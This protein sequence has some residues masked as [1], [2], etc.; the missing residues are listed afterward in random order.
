M[1]LSGNTNNSIFAMNLQALS[2]IRS[3]QGYVFSLYLDTRPEQIAG[4][5][6][7]SRFDRFLQ[8]TGQQ[9]KIHQAEPAER[10]EWNRNA[11]QIR[12]RLEG[13]QPVQGPGLAI[14]S[15]LA[16]DLWQVFNLPVP[17]ADRLV[18]N[19]CPYVRPL[20]ILLA[21]FKCTL[22]ILADTGSARL[23]Q[24]YPGA[25][26]EVD[27]LASEAVPV[28][29]GAED[30]NRFARSIVERIEAAWREKKCER[31]V[32][33]GSA[34]ALA[35]LENHLPDP[36]RPHVSRSVR[37]SPQAGLED[38][39][40]QVRE[41]E[42]EQEHNLET[43]RV[44]ELLAGG[45]PED[46]SAVLGLEQSLLAVRSK[47]VRVLV[48]EE[49]FHREGGVCPNCGFIG[50]GLEGVCLFC[51]MALRPE[52]DIIE[53]ALKHVLDQG[54]EI[55]VLRSPQAKGALAEHGHIGA[56][57]YSA[58]ALTKDVSNRKV[59]DGEAN[60]DALRDETVEES[61]PGSDPPSY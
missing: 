61:F 55:E 31:L 9:R 36:L 15:S 23:I 14:F 49:D 45:R 47:K 33:G 57:I 3:E 50:E 18:I 11:D 10:D 43:R 8:Q 2:E 25:A 21:E 32:L 44:E 39:L 27:R 37:L 58:E 48:V 35:L 20:E 56:L 30:P 29:A 13:E 34:E 22:V 4:E 42:N 28:E 41:I 40:T 46:D 19:D 17:P 16:S 26:Q 52:P 6:L 59:I 60:P 5:S 7:A 12:T 24:V 54:G 38:I 1:Q 53:A 51:G